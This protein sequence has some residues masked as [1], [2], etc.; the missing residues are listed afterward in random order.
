MNKFKFLI[1]SVEL[2]CLILY[3]D[4]ILSWMSL[5]SIC[6]TLNKLILE[7]V[8]GFML[9]KRLTELILLLD[10][11][12]NTDIWG[13][14]QKYCCLFFHIISQMIC[15]EIVIT[16]DIDHPHNSHFHWIGHHFSFSILTVVPYF[17]P[18]RFRDANV[19]FPKKPRRVI[20]KPISSFL[21]GVNWSALARV[22]LIHQGRIGDDR[23]IWQHGTMQ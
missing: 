23:L 13:S 7:L 12:Q 15:L 5:E 22:I 9:F 4:W 14:P 21:D 2:T 20:W 11:I 3:F 8:S 10:S 6:F 1:L 19:Q 17:R 18:F 16:S